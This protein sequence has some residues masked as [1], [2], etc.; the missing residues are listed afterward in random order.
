MTGHPLIHGELGFALAVSW[1]AIGFATYYF[2]SHSTAFTGRFSILVKSLDSQ[3]NKIMLQ[4]LL[5]LLF[6]GIFSAIIILVIPG[7]RLKDYGLGFSF[8]L[9]PPWWAYLLVPCILGLGILSAKT[10]RNLAMYP[11]IR[12][13]EWTPRIL[14]LSALSW[15]AFLV[16]YEFLF[17]GFLLHASL[18]LLP[19][20]PAIALNLA[21]YALA[22]VYKGPGET[23][24]SI[25]VGIVLCYLT[26]I[27][28]NIWSAVILHALMALSNEWFSLWAHPDMKI[29]RS[30]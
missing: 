17:R 20:L 4:R 8:S 19:G 26:L 18:D 30:R 24:G 27:T 5:G 29:I 10:P 2:L 11:Q 3:G 23:Y 12:M 16:G 25:P 1:C 28:G 7:A 6:L 14:V 15:I 13:R 21:L 22:H 9:A